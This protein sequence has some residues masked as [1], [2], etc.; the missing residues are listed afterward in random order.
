MKFGR[1]PTTERIRIA[2]VSQLRGDDDRRWNPRED[3]DDPP[4]GFRVDAPR[5]DDAV[6][7]AQPEPLDGH[8]A[9]ERVLEGAP[10][11]KPLAL[12]LDASGRE[13]RVLRGPAGRHQGIGHDGAGGDGVIP[14]MLYFAENAQA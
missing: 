8:A 13:L 3:A 4:L 14:R 10:F 12:P 2:S 7:G 9:R 5:H 1:A 11:V 6:A